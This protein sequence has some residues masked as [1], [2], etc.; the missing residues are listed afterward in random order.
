MKDSKVEKSGYHH[1]DLRAA[2]IAKGLRMLEEQDDADLSLRA[3]A[4]AVGVS[5]TAV[6]RHFPDK[7]ALREALALAAYDRLGEAQRAAAI[8]MNNV[9]D[10]F[11]AMGRTYVRFALDHPALFRLMTSIPGDGELFDFDRDQSD[12]QAAKL[13]RAYAR[14]L[15]GKGASPDTIKTIAMR[16]W[17][18]VHGLAV[19][20]IDGYVPRDEALID[21]VVDTRALGMHR[22]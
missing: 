12:D 20:M 2:L 18:L 16:A 19:L 5:A 4:R 10:E 1:G 22:G 9:F 8:G 3:L 11:Q 6:Y 17:A 21:A 13:L 7:E 15:A 14:K